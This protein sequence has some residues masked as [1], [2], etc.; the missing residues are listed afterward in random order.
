ML[1]LYIYLFIFWW[2]SHSFSRL[3]IWPRRVVFSIVKK[4]KKEAKNCWPRFDKKRNKKLKLK[5]KYPTTLSILLEWKIITRYIL[6]RKIENRVTGAF[7]G[8]ILCVDKPMTFH[9]PVGSA[10]SWFKQA[11]SNQSEAGFVTHR[12]PI[13]TV[14]RGHRLMNP[15]RYRKKQMKLL[16]RKENAYQN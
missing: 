5:K 1:L 8:S 13:W 11:S 3:D 12:K 15:I 6:T 14:S 2:H 10:F 7:K 9:K 4:K 16:K